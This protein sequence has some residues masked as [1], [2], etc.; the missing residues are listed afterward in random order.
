MK[1]VV[2]RIFMF[3]LIFSFMVIVAGFSPYAHAKKLEE[4]R[5]KHHRN[6]LHLRTFST[7][8]E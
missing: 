4:V 8:V 6:D 5:E 3:L 2:Y 1:N 7:Q